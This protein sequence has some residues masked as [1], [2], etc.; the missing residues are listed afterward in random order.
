M[1]K[2]RS[3][4]L[5]TSLF[6]LLVF[7]GFIILDF[8]SS[9]KASPVVGFEAG[10]IIDDSVFTNRNSMTAAQIQSFLNLMVPV[11]DTQGEQISEFGG[12]TRAEWAA[13]RGYY[14][15]FTCLKDF[16]E[17]GR[18][19]AQIIYDTAQEFSINPQVLIVLLQKEQVLI[20]DTWPIPASSQYRTATGY[21]CPDTAP[22]DS[23]YYGLTNQLRW[24]GTMFRAIMNN[25]PTWYTP[26]VL[27]NN[28]VQ[29]NP[30]TS[31]GGTTVNILNRSTQALYNYTPYQPNQAALNAGFGMGDSC[32]AYGNRNFYQYF[33]AWFG[34]TTGPEYSSELNSVRLYSDAA[35]TQEISKISGRYILIPGQE[36][37]SRVSATN[38]GRVQW[39]DSTRLGTANPR[40]RTS[41][42]YTPTW[43][44][45]Q[46][47]ALRS[48][49][50]A[51]YETADF[52]FKIKAPT[53]S[54]IYQE[55]FDFVQDG[56]MW[57]DDPLTISFQVVPST[58]SPAS[59]SDDFRLIPN[60]TLTQDQTLV[61][62]DGYSS[63]SHNSSGV[64]TL[65]TDFQSKWSVGGG[66]VS[67]N[68]LVMQGDG[69]L[70]LYNRNSV[71]LWNSGTAGN[72]NSSLYLQDDGNLV[73]YSQS[74]TPLWSSNTGIGGSHLV[75]PV[76]NIDRNSRIFPGQLFQS[77]DRRLTLF[78]Q[79]DGNFVL[80]SGTRAL[81]STQTYGKNAARLDFQ[82]DGNLVIYD[83]SNRPIWFS[84]TAGQPNARMIIQTDGNLVIYSGSN[85][86]WSTRTNGLR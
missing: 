68:R 57:F 31:C 30:N 32:S 5:T 69:N 47:T 61:S 12:G 79:E 25:S 85:G 36:A 78:F 1:K 55:T 46:R 13:A 83:T 50:S 45:N 59:V 56:K 18:S 80:Y 81:W 71:A 40:D 63:L 26:Y 52:D 16:S 19:A 49:G 9:T 27:G 29:F 23:Q 84:G 74:G 24:S 86:V 72:P 28:Y 8:S 33:K 10:R 43:I 77:Y 39:D 73:I 15:P 34:N 70:V 54:M 44:N 6:F 67:P 7:A 21:G 11:C 64:L 82:S 3:T 75:F 58:V 14:P 65:R 66:G 76:A 38:N 53:E 22:C 17:G 51:I 4:L 62:A 60:Q 41:L 48:G 42:F 20:T 35:F 2:I 37:F